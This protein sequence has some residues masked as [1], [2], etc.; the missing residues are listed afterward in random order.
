MNAMKNRM[1]N[2]NCPNCGAPI[3]IEQHK[4][5]YCGTSYYDLSY[6][7]FNEPFFL[8]LNVGAADNPRIITTKAIMTNVDLTQSIDQAPEIALTFVS[9]FGYLDMGGER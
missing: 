4:C 1:K 6:L 5:A 8:K 3:D 7:P 2:R 9:L